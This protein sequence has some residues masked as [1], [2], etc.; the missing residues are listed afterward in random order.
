[1]SRTIAEH[2]ADKAFEEGFA[3]GADA[4]S[5][6]RRHKVEPLTHQHWRAGFEAGR[7]ALAAAMT[8]RLAIRKTREP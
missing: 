2:I 3:F 6:R 5:G 8:E 4:M 1:M 7:A